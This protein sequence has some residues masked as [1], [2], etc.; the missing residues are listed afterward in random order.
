MIIVTV[1]P[2]IITDVVVAW[3]RATAATIFTTCM[4]RIRRPLPTGQAYRTHAFVTSGSKA[5]SVPAARTSTASDVTC[6]KT[7]L[8]LPAKV[9]K[10]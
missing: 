1:A 2:S 10:P 8:R 4:G 3:P 6:L 7:L 5:T 9:P